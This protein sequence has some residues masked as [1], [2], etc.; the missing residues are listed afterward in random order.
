MPEHKQ[1]NIDQL[2]IQNQQPPV[3]PTQTADGD[4]AGEQG[5]PGNNRSDTGGNG[6]QSDVTPD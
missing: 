2:R 3:E 5:A 4:E 1:T 6:H